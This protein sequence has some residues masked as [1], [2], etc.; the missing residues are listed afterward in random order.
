MFT[1]KRSL[2]LFAFAA[3]LITGAAA[4]A[5]PDIQHWVTANGARV[6]FVEA[7]QLP[8]VDIRV[9]FD[10]GSSR[11]PERAGL[12]SM[13]NGLLDLG[14]GG[15]TAQQLAERFEGVGAELDLGALRDMAWVGIRS[16]TDPTMLEPALESFTAILGRPDFPAADME[17]LRARKLV[18]LESDKQSPGTI[19]SK[20][21]YRTLFGEH[22]YALPTSGTEASVKAISRDEVVAFHR[23][24][25]VARNA[26]VAITGDLDRAGAERLAER[27]SGVLTSGE[28]P[29]PLP[30]VA[31]LNG[32]KE[33]ILHYPS[34]QSHLFIGQPGM[35]RGDPDYFALLLGNHALGGSGL[36]S[37]LS[38]EI[39]EKRGLAYSVYSHFAPMAET[40]PFLM[41]MQTKNDQA[42]QARGLL[43]E[44]LKRFI[45]E[46]VGEEELEEARANLTGGFALRVDSN[47]K[48]NEYLAMIG[49]YGLP[50]DYL[51]RFNERLEAV[52]LE[53]VREAFRR[54]LTPAR[55]V[56][57]IV[58]GGEGVAK[59]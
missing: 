23:R 46:G 22:P 33:A 41:G 20:A 2:S 27:L 9:L 49:F 19:A 59:D 34:S 3:L 35:K 6:Y 39:R 28:K 57:V 58:G 5:A 42:E 53:Q 16:V 17:R 26:T 36:V 44:N 38:G 32:A 1:L 21:F 25:Y 37:R 50:L 10:A 4:H 55:M 56:T 14:A 8:M 43:M 31:P 7:R 18:G 48:I 11:A 13:T 51:D 52:T 30:P 45:D 40:G 15:L 29:A 47:R 12:A 54:R 24:Y